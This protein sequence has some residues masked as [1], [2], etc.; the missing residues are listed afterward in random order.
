MPASCVRC[1]E[2]RTKIFFFCESHTRSTL[3]L[4]EL[5][6]STI[7]LT[8]WRPSTSA[9]RPVQYTVR[10]Q[11]DQQ[12]PAEVHG[13]FIR[14][15]SHI[16]SA[17]LTLKLAAPRVVLLSSS[18]PLRLSASRP[19]A[20][21][22]GPEGF[23]PEDAPQ[24]GRVA[25]V[26]PIALPVRMRVGDPMAASA[27]LAPRRAVVDAD[28]RVAPVCAQAPRARLPAVA[29]ALDTPCAG[30]RPGAPPT[31][32]ASRRLLFKDRDGVVQPS[33]VRSLSH[34]SRIDD[35]RVGRSSPRVME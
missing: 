28:D 30:A 21:L 13:F 26:I 24:L 31:P 3:A 7:P 4:E 12:T 11:T 2:V 14:I 19:L 29:V 1:Q 33:A 32:A 17:P 23:A 22:P 10:P 9:H 25:R 5:P 20:D 18:P 16:G 27:L 6:P 35:G 8:A 15:L 34:Q